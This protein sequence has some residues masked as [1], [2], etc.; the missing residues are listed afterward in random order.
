MEMTTMSSRF[1]S[2]AL[3]LIIAVSALPANADI[4][5]WLD[6]SGAKTY[7]DQPPPSGVQLLNVVREPP[8]KPLTAAEI[9]ARREAVQQA[10]IQSLTDRLR[11]LEREVQMANR[12]APPVQYVLPPASSPCDPAWADC[13]GPSSAPF[14]TVPATIIQF[15]QHQHHFGNHHFGNHHF[16]NQ[17]FPNQHFG[18]HRPMGAPGAVHGPRR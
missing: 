17:F 14:Y 1:L 10:Q 9:A 13:V 7:S 5:T 4:Y 15:P 11:L 8:V 3:P 12:P 18:G 2:T 16:R 6:P